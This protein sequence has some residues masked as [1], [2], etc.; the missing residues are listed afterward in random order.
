M[1]IILLF[2]AINIRAYEISYSIQDLDNNKVIEKKDEQK[3]MVLASVSKLYSYYYILKNTDLKNSFKTEILKSDK[4]SIK[5]GILSGDLIIKAS[6]DP[7]IT[8]QNFLDLIFQI[9]A[10][11]IRKIN[12]NFYISEQDLWKT[13]R[14]SSLGLEDQA[15]NTSMGPFNF[16]F[17]RFKSV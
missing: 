15:D 6:G 10:K 17:N 9:K 14:L 7:F 1:K 3:E 13:E 8:A 2:L 11:G 12:G 16:E 4:A 5:D